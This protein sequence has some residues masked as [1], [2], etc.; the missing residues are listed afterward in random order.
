[1]VQS[2]LFLTL[3]ENLRQTNRV[4]VA[5]EAAVSDP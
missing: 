4:A 2:G 1:V 5:G 3:Q